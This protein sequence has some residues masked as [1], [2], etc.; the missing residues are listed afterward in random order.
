M[1]RKTAV[2]CCAIIGCAVL[3]TMVVS[4]Q[5]ITLKPG[6]IAN[7]EFHR[8]DARDFAYC[9]IAPVLG[10]PPNVMAQFYNSSGPGDRCPAIEMAA[11]D[12][13]KLAAELGAEFVYINP[14][15]QTARRH[16]VMDQ[17]W[18]FK[19]GETVD[20]HGVRATWA[21]T[22]SPEVMNGLLRSDF[23]PGEIHRDSKYLYA[24]GSTVFLLRSPDG[25]TWVMQSYT[26]EVDKDLSF[27]QL[28]NLASELK[29]PDGFKFEVKTLTR[30]LT[31]DPRKADDVAH[32][33]RDNLHDIYGGCGFDG[34]CNYIP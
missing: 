3:F 20:F 11:L 21:A 29:L 16:W 9:E 4:A 25:K 5:Q 8:A 7:N 12:P 32:I 30:D 24:K 27:D 18:F 14:T 26:T 31:I 28:S 33:I 23:V 2:A 22:M 10:K 6:A 19:V 17:L 34:A 1:T 13:K 15:P